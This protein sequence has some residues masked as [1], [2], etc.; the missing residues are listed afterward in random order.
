[1]IATSQ[2]GERLNNWI[3]DH[4]AKKWQSRDLNPSSLSVKAGLLICV[5]YRWAVQKALAQVS[6]NWTPS[7]P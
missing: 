1:M 6:R 2:G 5:T 3:W 4:K 7:G